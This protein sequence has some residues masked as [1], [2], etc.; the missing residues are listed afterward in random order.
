[1]SRAAAP[2]PTPRR[3]PAL[4]TPPTP[5]PTGVAT[6]L[7]D[8]FNVLHAGF[9]EKRKRTQWWTAEHR[10]RLIEEIRQFALPAEALW[11]VFDGPR[12]PSTDD[13]RELDRTA[14]DS[15]LHLV[16]ASCADDWLIRRVREAGDPST[17]AVVTGDRAVANRARHH[18]AYVVSPRDFLAHCGT[19]GSN[20]ELTGDAPL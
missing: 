4:A 13:P 1:M 18:H 10:D 2:P 19:C 16:F 3:D 7:I 12:A 17:V 5:L 6:W 15:L 11:I 14:A 20:G 8:G 9:F